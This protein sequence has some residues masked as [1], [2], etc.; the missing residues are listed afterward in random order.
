MKGS[1]VFPSKWLKADDLGD[2]EPTVIISQV[3][4]EEIGN[5]EP[6]KPVIYFRGKQKGMVCNKTNWNRIAYIHKSDDS[7]DWPGKKI[8]LYVEIVDMRGE[9]KPA[10]RVKAPINRGSNA[11]AKPQQ[12]A[13]PPDNGNAYLD[14]EE[15]PF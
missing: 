2:K 1:D 8:T 4:M 13:P 7:D 5:N 11:N 6:K 10:L 14:G 3:V 15:I 12:K 9:M